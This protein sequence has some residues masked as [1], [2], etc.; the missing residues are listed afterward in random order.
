[1]LVNREWN[2]V[3]GQCS[4]NANGAADKIAKEALS[5][6]RGMHYFSQPVQC[7]V[8]V[9]DVDLLQGQYSSMSISSSM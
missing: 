3:V 7:L 2:I 5:N 6:P 4:I 8:S 1:M 9:L